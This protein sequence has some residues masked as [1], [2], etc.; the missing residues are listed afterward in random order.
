MNRCKKSPPL[1]RKNSRKPNHFG[2]VWQQGN[3]WYG[4]VKFRGKLIRTCGHSSRAKAEAAMQKLTTGIKK[5]KDCKTTLAEW[6]DIWLNACKYKIEYNTYRNYKTAIGHVNRY[7]GKGRLTDISA[8]EVTAVYTALAS[9]GYSAAT[10]SLVAATLSALCKYAIAC[11]RIDTDFTIRAIRPRIEKRKYRIFTPREIL[12]FTELIEKERLKFPMLFML[13]LGLRRGEAMAVKWENIDLEKKQVIISRQLVLENGARV[14][15]KPK[16]DTSVRA[17]ILPE[18]LVKRLEAVPKRNRRTYPY[19]FYKTRPEALSRDF[20]RIAKTM[21]I[22]NM[23]LY[24]L[25]H[26]FASLSVYD[27]VA[28]KEVAEQLGHSTDRIINSIYVHRPDNHKSACAK[29]I[30]DIFKDCKTTA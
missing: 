12:R 3:F 14:T 19:N 1:K 16:T 10:I 25:R 5:M 30:D 13:L 21:G 28:L 7:I 29:V 8:H 15:K 27:G 6:A 2:T 26:T 4:K 23:R 22:N 17:L 24:D 18:F 9:E 11:E 20:K